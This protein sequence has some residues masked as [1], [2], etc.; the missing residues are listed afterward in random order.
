MN[1]KKETRFA[2]SNKDKS[3]IK[4][5]LLIEMLASVCVCLRT[6]TFELQLQFFFLFVCC[7][8]FY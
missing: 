4:L 2:V 8:C 7:C 6:C 1:K 5:W 3:I